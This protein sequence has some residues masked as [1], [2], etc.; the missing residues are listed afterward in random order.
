MHQATPPILHPVISQMYLEL[1]LTDG[2][3]GVTW[4]PLSSLP[5]E[6][7]RVSTS[8]P[9]PMKWVPEGSP[10]NWAEREESEREMERERKP[11]SSGG[12]CRQ[13]E[14]WFDLTIL[15][16]TH[17]SLYSSSKDRSWGRC[18][19]YLLL[20]KSHPKLQQLKTTAILLYVMSLGVRNLDRA[21]L[22]IPPSR[23][24][25]PKALGC[26]QL[27]VDGLDCWLGGMTGRLSSVGTIDQRACTPPWLHSDLR[28]VR[29]GGLGL[30]ENVP[31]DPHG[32]CKV[33]YDLA[34]EVPEY[35]FY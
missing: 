25:S 2:N 33:S 29:P 20:Q 22:R 13:Q 23:V 6:D 16:L 8:S 9:K 10:Q 30:S 21:L 32:S 11:Q 31:R 28:I 15:L 14:M 18:S 19:G 24:V 27:L 26:V 7:G 5:V 34:W 12:S 17:S 1:F 4:L 35:P 3:R